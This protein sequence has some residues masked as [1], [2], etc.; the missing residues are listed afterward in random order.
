[1]R[2]CRLAM[3]RDLSLAREAG[4]FRFGIG[5]G[6]LETSCVRACL[7]VHQGED[8]LYDAAER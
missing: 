2:Q 6:A 1:M 3:F 8:L 4:D 7:C 5:Q